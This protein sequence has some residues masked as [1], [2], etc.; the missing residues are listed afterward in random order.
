[1]NSP[2]RCSFAIECYVTVST[3]KTGRFASGGD[4]GLSGD[5]GATGSDAFGAIWF[6]G[7]DL[8]LCLVVSSLRA[9]VLL[10]LPLRAWQRV[11]DRQKQSLTYVGREEEMFFAFG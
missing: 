2:N 10:G 5:V 8:L 9:H 6:C 3:V 11:R 4:V 1:M 7:A